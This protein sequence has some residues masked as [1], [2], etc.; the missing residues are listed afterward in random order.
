[1]A[2]LRFVV[3]CLNLNS[4]IFERFFDQ[5]RFLVIAG[6]LPAADIH[7]V[8]VIAGSLTVGSLILFAEVSAA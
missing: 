7:L 1:M 2:R 6:V 4:L 8:L 3:T 5:D